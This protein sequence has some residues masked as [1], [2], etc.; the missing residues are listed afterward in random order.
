MAV[1]LPNDGEIFLIN[2]PENPYHANVKSGPYH[3]TSSANFLLNKTIS[4]IG[5]T[6]FK[7]KLAR[8]FAHFSVSLVSL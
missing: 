1:N 5:L 4:S 3:P 2:N 7:Y 8:L 6:V